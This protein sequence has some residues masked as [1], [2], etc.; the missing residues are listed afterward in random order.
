MT[1]GGTPTTCVYDGDGGRVK[2]TVG[3]TTTTYIGKL[4]VCEGGGCAKLLYAGG[5]R[6]AIKQVSSGSISYFHPDHLGF[7]SVLTNGS[8]TKEEDLVDYPYGETYTNTGT[9]NVAYKYTGKELDDSTGLYFYE[10]RYYDAVLGRFISA[11]TIIPSA[12]NPQSFNRYSYANNNPI[13][14]NDP[15]GH[16]AFKSIKK[17]FKKVENFSWKSRVYFSGGGSLVLDRAL[18]NKTIGPYARIAFSVAASYF[19]GPLGAAGAQAYMT[20]LDGGSVGASLKAG[21]IS[22]AAAYIGGQVGGAVS[23]AAVDAGAS[24]AVG[25]IAGAAVAGALNGAISSTLAGGDPGQGALY[26]AAY[27]AAFAAASIAAEEAYNY[28]KAKLVV[29]TQQMTID[30]GSVGTPNPYAQMVANAAPPCGGPACNLTI[31]FTT[32]PSDIPQYNSFDEPYALNLLVA[33]SHEGT[34]AIFQQGIPIGSFNSPGYWSAGIYMKGNGPHYCLFQTYGPGSFSR[35]DPPNGNTVR[36]RYVQS[37]QGG[38]DN[39]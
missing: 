10:S 21:V 20:R 37:S 35:G 34:V 16:F 22:G 17:A 5:Q 8:G 19:G 9:A 29:E 4:Y 36:S 7:T 33:S 24:A 27:G 2:K 39:F 28:Y 6:I 1:Q 3:T 18:T 26:G 11:D 13:I 30:L 38:K 23:S 14:F 15:S 31:Q 12:S 25:S 32:I